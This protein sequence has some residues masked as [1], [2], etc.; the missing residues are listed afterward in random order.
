MFHYKKQRF[1]DF[2]SFLYCSKV[3][4]TRRNKYKIQIKVRLLKLAITNHAGGVD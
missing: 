1:I 3:I 2:I 4:Y